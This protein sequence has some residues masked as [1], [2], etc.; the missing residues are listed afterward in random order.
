MKQEHMTENDYL[1]GIS[2]Q[3]QNKAELKEIWNDYPELVAGTLVLEGVNTEADV[4]GE[5]E[6]VPIPST[7]GDVC[8]MSVES[9]SAGA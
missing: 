7:P 1:A 4:S 8:T 6:F 3:D 2:T 5:V 9:P